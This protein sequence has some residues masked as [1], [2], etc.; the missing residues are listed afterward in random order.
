MQ[1]FKQQAILGVHLIMKKR[2]TPL[3]LFNLYGDEGDKFVA[4]GMFFRRA[5]GWVIR[6]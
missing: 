4:G 6:D 3:N 2:A 1:E 5:K